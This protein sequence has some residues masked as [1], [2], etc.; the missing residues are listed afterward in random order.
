MHTLS[1]ETHDE[2]HWKLRSLSENF[3]EKES[4]LGANPTLEKLKQAEAMEWC[5][6]NSYK[7]RRCG[8]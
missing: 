3:K 1:L 6:Q 2:A 4:K 7:S 8:L 5:L